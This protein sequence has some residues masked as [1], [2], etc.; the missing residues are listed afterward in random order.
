MAQVKH[1]Q[2]WSVRVPQSTGDAFVFDGA[3]TVKESVQ[4]PEVA[5]VVENLSKSSLNWQIPENE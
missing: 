1:S 2:C 3:V 4:M 5:I